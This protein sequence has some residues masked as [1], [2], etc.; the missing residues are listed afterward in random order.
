MKPKKILINYANDA[1]KKAQKLNSKTGIE[2]GGF[3][4]VIEYGPKD[5]DK[6]FYEKNKHIL[7]QLRGGGYWLWKP[8]IIL[9]TLKR[10]DVKEG[11]YVFYA[12]SG[13]YFI[14]KIDYLINLSK[15]YN[16]DIIPFGTKDKKYLEKYWTK[17]DAFI[18][19][20]LD[21]KKYIET[22][23]IG[24]TFILIKKSKKSKKF[25]RE[26]LEYAQDERIITDMPSKLGKNYPGFIEN[27]H[28]QSI[29]SLLAKKYNLRAFRQPFETDEKKG[30]LFPDRYPQIVVLTR[31]NNRNLIEKIKYQ[32]ACSK[33]ILD[34]IVRIIK[35]SIQ[36]ILYKNKIT[37]RF[38]KKDAKK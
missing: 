28:D 25:F 6:K 12:D 19:M 17:R 33:N 14:N 13:S 20:K 1:F 21:D 23:Q 31:K 16:Q 26:F 37:P 18:L 22:R 7:T 10:K 32:R 2:V 9:K 34:F 35:I 30:N 5:I 15:K 11:D 36:K 29:F 38:S 27:R 8:Y 3:D 4:K 24:A